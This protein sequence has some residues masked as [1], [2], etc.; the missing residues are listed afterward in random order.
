[1]EVAATAT[2]PAELDV[3]VMASK[4]VAQSMPPAA[5]AVADEAGRMEADMAG[6]SS[7]VVVVPRR[8]RR[9]PPPA[10]LSGGSRSPVQ[11]EPPLQ[12]MDA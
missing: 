10:P 12:W 9:E 11:E 3:V 8:I 6:G 5:P 1:M 7:G 4:G 2:S